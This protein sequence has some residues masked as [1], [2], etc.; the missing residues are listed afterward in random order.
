M[1]RFELCENCTTEMT[2]SVPL[3][4]DKAGSENASGFALPE[5]CEFT[6]RKLLWKARQ[7]EEEC[8]LTGRKSRKVC[9]DRSKG[10]T[11]ED[12]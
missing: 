3:R 8:S 6:K 12:P 1:P 9:F 7:S 10:V 4:H 11:S 5:L 2:G